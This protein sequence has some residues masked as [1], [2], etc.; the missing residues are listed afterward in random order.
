MTPES[1]S[2]IQNLRDE[3]DKL[4]RV[5]TEVMG[6]EFDTIMTRQSESQQSILRWYVQNLSV[7]VALM[8]LLVEKG[9]LDA[10]ECQQRIDTLRERLLSRA[11][12]IGMDIDMSE[13]A[14]D[15]SP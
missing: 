8:Q 11:D 9:V 7:S 5:I 1:R 3:V 13:L 10:P 14:R 15:S 6:E 12:S 4:S 2:E